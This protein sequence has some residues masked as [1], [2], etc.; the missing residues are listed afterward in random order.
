MELRVYSSVYGSPWVWRQVPFFLWGEQDS[1][2][3]GGLL[4]SVL[5]LLEKVGGGVDSQDVARSLS[6]DHQVVVGAVKSLQA[7]GEVSYRAETPG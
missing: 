4:E 7:L 3:D 2:A 1:M 6:V 5:K